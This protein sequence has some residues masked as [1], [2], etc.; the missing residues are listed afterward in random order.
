MSPGEKLATTLLSDLRSEFTAKPFIPPRLLAQGDLQTLAAFFWPGRFRSRDATGDEERLFEVE[1]EIRVLGH[2]R[3]QPQRLNSPTLVMWHGIEGSSAAAYMLSTAAKAFRAGFNVIRM[4]LRN[5]GETDNLTP[6]L[7]HAGLTQ[8]AR[9]VIDEL[10][11]KDHLARI[12]V[13]GFSLGGN[14]VLKLAGEYGDL[15]PSELR[16]VVAISPSVDLHA[17]SERLL[18]KRNWIYHQRFLMALKRRIQIKEKLYP[19]LYQTDGLHRL[20]TIRAFDDKYVAPAFGFAGAD[21]YYTKAS[22]LPYLK[23]IRIPTLIIHAQDD[24]FIPFASLRDPSVAANPHLLLLAPAR[25]GHVAF[26]SRTP[27]GEDRFWAENRLMDFCRL[28]TQIGPGVRDS[29][30]CENSPAL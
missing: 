17:S 20:K 6:T 4:N 16:G 28:C 11:N 27:S 24:P 12:V 2:C 30:R 21:D 1:S 5:C 19:E 14:Q 26:I 10:I 9:K 22:S 8:D 25:G 3:W 18:A 13:A 15:P 23:D 7:Y 29:G